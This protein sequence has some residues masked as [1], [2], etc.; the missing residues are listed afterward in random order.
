MP[1]ELPFNVVD[2][3]VEVARKHRINGFICTNLA[4]NRNNPNVKDGNVPEK[5]GMSGMVVQGLSDA[6]IKHIYARTRGEFVIMGCGG[7]F[8]AEDAYRKIK[9]GANLIQ[10]ITGM[11]YQGPQ[12]I[13]EIN[14]GLVQLL[15]RDG[16]DTIS[17]AV[18]TG[19]K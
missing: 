6:L 8:T 10:L 16:Y 12:V 14:Q 19:N 18:G 17:E 3:M 9:L 13:S 2:D 15:K 7:V 1:S 4:K 11:V 5:G